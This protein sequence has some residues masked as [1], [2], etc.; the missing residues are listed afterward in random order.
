M[1]TEKPF[2]R[3]GRIM[4]K[5]MT[6]G[7]PGKILFLFAI[8]MVLGNMFQQLYSIIDSMIVGKFVGAEAL[9]AVGAS[10]PI[11]FV[12]ITIAN[13]AGIGCSVVIAQ[14]FGAKKYVEV[15]SSI[16]TSL[17]SM[18]VISL[19]I[20]II[21][22]LL[23]ENILTLMNTP[24]DIFKDAKVYLQIYFIGVVFLFIYN[25]VNSSFNSLGDSKTPLFFLIFSSLVN[26][27]LD[28]IFVINFNMGVRGAAIA[29]SISQGISA[30]LSVSFLYKRIKKMVSCENLKVFNFSI[31]KSIG[32]IAL[33]SILQQSVISI[34]NLFV[35]AL[36]NSF[37]SI[38]IAGYTAASKIDSLSILP[39]A[40]MSNAVSAFSAQNIGGNKIDRVYKGY[41]AALRIIAVFCI[42]IAVIIF[43][44]GKQIIG[45]FVNEHVSNEVISF[46]ENYLRIVSLCY[47]F[48]GFMVITN[49]IL[50]A[51]GD[52]K[53]FLIT[54][55]INL[56]VRVIA[57][58]VLSIVLFENSIACAVPLGWI[59]ASIF[60]YI[61]YKSGSWK[62]KKAV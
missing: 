11:T 61:R 35:Q 47:F 21:G 56:S 37:G 12:C 15:K 58:Y 17:I 51:A 6:K 60:V 46:G 27:I 7:N 59:M 53:N 23:T 52:M 10:Y 4:I 55:F 34:G 49:G 25:I 16:Y 13:G 41:R 54:S 44:Y 31:F 5:D 14:F 38:V 28:L 62:D 36:V 20:S 3:E 8:P 45:L 33:P 29:T 18:L 1:G 32:R 26:I 57:S 40:N 48:M 43:L 50:R 19:F 30:V 2:R 22:Y 42:V 9:A 39:M 24:Y